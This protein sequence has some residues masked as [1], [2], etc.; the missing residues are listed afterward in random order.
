VFLPTADAANGY[1]EPAYGAQAFTDHR[2]EIATEFLGPNTVLGRSSTARITTRRQRPLQPRASRFRTRTNQQ[3]GELPAFLLSS[4]LKCSTARY[5]PTI[6]TPP[7]FRPATP[8][9][10]ADALSFAVRYQ[11]VS[12]FTMLTT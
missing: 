4:C 5:C 6:S 9:E 12:G 7:Y 11:D 1:Q 10:I 8:G 2:N 3:A